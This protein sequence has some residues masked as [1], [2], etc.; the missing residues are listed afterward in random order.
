MESNLKKGLAILLICLLLIVFAFI[1]YKQINGYLDGINKINEDKKIY[2]EQD[3]DCVQSTC[4]HASSCVNIKYAEKCSG[5]FCTQ[6]CKTL[7]DCGQASCKCID[8]KCAV[9]VNVK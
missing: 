9:K 8:N 1:V 2:C 4:C 6:E 5:I 7:L 3:S